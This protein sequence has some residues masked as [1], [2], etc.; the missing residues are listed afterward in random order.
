MTERL[1]AVFQFIAVRLVALA[2][3][4][5]VLGCGRAADSGGPSEL[6]IER[7][8]AEATWANAKPGCS[9]GYHYTSTTSSVFGSCAETTIHVANDQVIGRSFVDYTSG[10]CGGGDAAPAEI[11]S[12][13]PPDIGMH[14]DGAAPLTVEQLF[15]ACRISLAQDRTANTFTLTIGTDGVPTACGYTPNACVDDCF[16]GFILS[17]FACGDWTFDAGPAH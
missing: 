11:W 6:E 16:M 2:L 15:E 5:A 9:Q 12:E 17:D 13:L 8:S 3:A 10:G 4:G 7:Q 1:F 14:S